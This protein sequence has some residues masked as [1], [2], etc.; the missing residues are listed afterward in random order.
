MIFLDFY[1]S[2]FFGI[3][4]FFVFL[5]LIYISYLTT[6]RFCVHRNFEIKFSLILMVMIIVIFGLE[7]TLIDFYFNY[8]L[9]SFDI[10]G[11]GFFSPEEDTIEKERFMNRAT[12]DTGKFVFFF[13]LPV[14]S[15]LISFIAYAILKI[16]NLIKQKKESKK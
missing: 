6:K 10:D 2:P 13:M 15:I 16:G 12:N 8:K 4:N 14:A 5:S 9:E 7:M 11:D 1:E 3:F